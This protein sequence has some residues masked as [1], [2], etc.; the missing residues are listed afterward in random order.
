MFRVFVT[1]FLTV[2]SLL[3]SLSLPLSIFVDRFR[4]VGLCVRMF[5]VKRRCSKNGCIDIEIGSVKLLHV[6][7]LYK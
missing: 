4:S 5:Y 6:S 3:P 1:F 2:E 7:V